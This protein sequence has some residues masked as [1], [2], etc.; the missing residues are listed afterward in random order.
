MRFVY[1]TVFTTYKSDCYWPDSANGAYVSHEA[2]CVLNPY[3]EEVTVNL[4][5]YF[6]DRPPVG[7]CSVTP[8]TK[9]TAS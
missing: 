3:E 7:G 4:T 2:V 9:S 5:L 1:N 6:E 8:S